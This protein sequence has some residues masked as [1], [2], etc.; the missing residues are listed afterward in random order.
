EAREEFRRQGARRLECAAGVYLSRIAM[1][2]GDVALA[3]REARTALAAATVPQLRARSLAALALAVLST[4]PDRALEY[5]REAMAILEDTHG[6]E[7]GDALIRWAHAEALAATG[8]LEEAK[9]TISVSRQRL[10][11]K[12]ERIADVG[13]RASFLDGVPDH[14]AT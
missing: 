14:A 1:L 12:A 2:A 8:N 11:S 5:T 9:R 4:T 6:M 7:E 13:R 10:L 3:E